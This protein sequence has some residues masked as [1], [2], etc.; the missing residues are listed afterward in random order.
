M[1]NLIDAPND[2]DE[3]KKTCKAIIETPKGRRSK[4]NYNPDYGVFELGSLMPKGLV[5]PY[6]FGFIPSTKGEDGDPL[7]VLVL[8]DE[9]AH[10]GCLLDIRLIGVIEAE[11]TEDDG[12]KVENDRLIGVAVHAH[13]NADLQDVREA[14]EQLMHEVE[15]F[16]VTNAKEKGR[17]YKLR[18]LHGPSRAVKLLRDGMK[19]YNKG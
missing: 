2:F 7:D 10:V 14:G 5:F 12:K 16:F 19:A 11:Q 6:D 17:K 15:V 9:P 8:M 18:G 4:F 13:E 3:K 1:R